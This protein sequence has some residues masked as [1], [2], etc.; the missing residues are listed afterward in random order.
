[1]HWKIHYLISH[2]FHSMTKYISHLSCISFTSYVAFI[3]I[4]SRSYL[5]HILNPN[6]DVAF[7]IEKYLFSVNIYFFALSQLALY[8]F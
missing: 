4:V 7:D 3:S 1:M 2:I 8:I 5:K 6:T